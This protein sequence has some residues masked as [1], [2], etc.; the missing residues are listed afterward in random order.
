MDKIKNL[1]TQLTTG[2]NKKF[3]YI[4]LAIVVVLI[5]GLGINKQ[6]SL[7]NRNTS[8]EKDKTDHG[9]IGI[10]EDDGTRY[11]NFTT[12]IISYIDSD[13]GL[14]DITISGQLFFKE[15]YDKDYYRANPYDKKAISKLIL[16]YIQD[17]I[18][19]IL[20]ENEDLRYNHLRDILKSDEIKEIIDENVK[21]LGFEFVKVDISTFTLTKESM[22]KIQEIEISKRPTFPT[23]QPTQ[24]EENINNENP[25]EN[26]SNEDKNPLDE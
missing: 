10:K 12:N 26:E 21:A 1:I 17:A 11:Y 24:S 8:N 19:K 16:V 2:K 23:E 14:L 4:G 7:K 9:Y 15:M 5:I 20:N 13:Y 22:D 25:E 6:S 3:F 18:Y